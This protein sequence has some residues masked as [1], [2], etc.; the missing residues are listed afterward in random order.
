METS[1]VRHGWA[2]RELARVL[3]WLRAPMTEIESA[4]NRAIALLPQ[5]ERFVR[6]LERIREQRQ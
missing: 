2:W 1:S 3:N 4:Y 5:E 6:E